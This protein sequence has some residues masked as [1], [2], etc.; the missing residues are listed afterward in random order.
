VSGGDEERGAAGR[1]EDDGGA[2]VLHVDD[3]FDGEGRGLV[4]GG[5]AGEGVVD[6][7]QALVGGELGRIFHHAVDEGAQFAAGGFDDGVTGPA[8]G[9]ID[10]EDAFGGHGG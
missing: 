6:L 4:F 7:A 3:A 9:R 1:A 10:G 5:D 8:E 2:D